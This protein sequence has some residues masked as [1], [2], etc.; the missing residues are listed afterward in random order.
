MLIALMLI[1]LASCLI[2]DDGVNATQ[3]VKS[4]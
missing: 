2:D 1:A 3:P 4:Y